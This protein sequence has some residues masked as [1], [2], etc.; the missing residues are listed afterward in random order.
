[1]SRQRIYG[2]NG[3]SLNEQK[4]LALAN[5]LADAGYAVKLGKEKDAAKKS[6]SYTHFV[7]FWEDNNGSI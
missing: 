3:R 7:E 4:R 2:V 5:L 1:M 6:G